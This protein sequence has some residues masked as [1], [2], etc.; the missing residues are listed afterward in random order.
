M[1]PARLVECLNERPDPNAAEAIWKLPIAFKLYAISLTL[2]K[3]L[4]IIPP[5][6]KTKLDSK[7][8]DC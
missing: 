8:L 6:A 3:L 5:F 1:V 4:I 2:F 7:Y